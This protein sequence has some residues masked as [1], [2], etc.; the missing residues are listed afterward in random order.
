[1]IVRVATLD[2]D[3]KAE[4]KGHIWVSH[5]LPWLDYSDQVPSYDEIP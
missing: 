1:V 4:I 3:P 5:D 2:E